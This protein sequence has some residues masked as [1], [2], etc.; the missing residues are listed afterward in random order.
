MYEGLRTNLP[1]VS[2]PKA[3]GLG[4]SDYTLLCRH[5]LSVVGPDGGSGVG[6]S[7]SPRAHADTSTS[8]M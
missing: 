1:Y 2:S 4:T 3:S 5:R 6:V 7:L 8:R